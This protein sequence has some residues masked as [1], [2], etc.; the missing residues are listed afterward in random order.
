MSLTIIDENKCK[1][2]NKVF[3]YNY[4]LI[5]HQSRKTSCIPKS[6]LKELNVI[7]LDDKITEIDTIIKKKYDHSMNSKNFKCYFCLVNFATKSNLSRHCLSY[8]NKKKQLINEKKNLLLSKKNLQEKIYQNS[9]VT[10]QNINIE[11]N[12]NI[13]VNIINPF[14]INSFGQEDVTHIRREDYIK[15]MSTY[16]RGFLSFIENIHFNKNVPENHNVY[17]S[18][19]NSKYAI[20]YENSQW[21]L[22]DRDE[23][24]DKIK[25]DKFNFLDRKVDEMSDELDSKIKNKFEDFRNKLI[26]LEEADLNTQKDIKLMLYNNR[27][28][29]MQ[30][31]KRDEINTN[32]NT[33]TNTTNTNQIILK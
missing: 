21:K 8:C 6:A 30:N 32:I 15:Y 24:I 25:S 9:N 5:R 27:H 19:I 11:N 17:I 7:G 29:S 23:V 4:L 20:V 22:K 13:V 16:F 31:R 3:A 18:N 26:E 14:K 33:N 2:C 28:L 10:T 1:K 12:T